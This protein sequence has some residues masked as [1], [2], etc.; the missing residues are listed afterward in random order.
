MTATDERADLDA[1]ALL[2]QLAR[3][4]HERDQWRAAYLA[5][6]ASADLASAAR[7]DYWANGYRAGYAAG[8][9]VG[10]GRAAYVE[11]RCIESHDVGWHSPALDGT[12]GAALDARRYPS[13][14]GRPAGRA[15]WLIGNLGGTWA[16]W[17]DWCAEQDA[18]EGGE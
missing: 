15:G 6:S 11:A 17:S 9:E 2:A 5:A 8:V 12:P 4:E 1:G 3:V 18:R 16:A 7:L 10:N 13:H 14:D